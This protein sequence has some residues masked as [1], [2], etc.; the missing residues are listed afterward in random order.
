MFVHWQN[1]MT[2]LDTC[3]NLNKTLEKYFAICWNIAPDNW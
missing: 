2:G 3:N 1:I